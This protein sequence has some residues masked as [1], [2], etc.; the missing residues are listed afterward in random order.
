MTVTSDPSAPKRRPLQK[1]FTDVPPGYDLMNR[2]LTL[3]FDEKWRKKAALECVS[4]RT[5]KVLDLCTGT[6]DL[7]LHISKKLNGESVITGLDY[8]RPMLEIARQKSE[9][10]GRGNIAFVEGDA[11]ALPFKDSELDAIGI[12]FAFRN[13]SYK[14]PDRD[15]FLSEI[16]RVLSDTGKF[17]IVETSQPANRL[18][19]WFFHSYLR[20]V[21]A[22][23]GGWLSGHRSA[24]RYLSASAVNF[25]PP[26]ELAQLLRAA[27]FK[28]IKHRALLGGIAAITTAQKQ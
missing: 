24:Y 6:G 22:G 3:R 4:G 14:N 11:A 9:K 5:A 19:R 7:A 10:S 13:L 15:K 8:S 18:I 25:Y 27:G 20:I 23:L 16:V 1:M 26:D 12:A 17:V 2:I 21:V 28:S